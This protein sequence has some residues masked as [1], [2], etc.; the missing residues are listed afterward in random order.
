MAIE[1]S[2]HHLSGDE[3]VAQGGA[4]LGPSPYD[5]LTA[6]LGECTAMTVRWYAQREGW[7]LEH[8]SVAVEHGKRAGIDG[9]GVIDE[10]RKVVTVTGA[11][12]SDEQRRK[13]VE[14]AE[15]CPVHKTLTGTIR[16]TTQ[17]G[18]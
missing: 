5:L 1:V 9:A 18:D 4:N 8:V 16:I 17:A 13:L 6:A 12:L 15:R 11:D 2:G 14:V 7:P 10:F 3:P